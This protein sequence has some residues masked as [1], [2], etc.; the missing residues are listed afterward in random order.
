[1]LWPKNFIIV[2]KKDTANV[3]FSP[4]FSSILNVK[5]TLE[6]GKLRSCGFRF[7]DILRKTVLDMLSVYCL[8][9]L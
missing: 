8:E 3:L 5:H 2:F 9:I 4:I 7:L 1:M 6:G